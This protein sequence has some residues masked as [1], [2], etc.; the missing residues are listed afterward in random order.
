MDKHTLAQAEEDRLNTM[1]VLVE[2]YEREHF[3]IDTAD[4]IEA[5]RFRLEQMGYETLAEQTKILMPIMGTRARVHE[6]MHKSRGLS[7]RMVSG[8][9]KKF[10]APRS[11]IRPGNT[12]KSAKKQS[13]R[14]RH[15]SLG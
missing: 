4:P 7:P 14:P 10:E 3:P 12:A 11:R 8:L 1:T 6:V 2:A 5:I 13:H 9:W 15:A